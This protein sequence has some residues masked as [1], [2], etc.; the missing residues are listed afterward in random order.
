MRI[1][2]KKET[3]LYVSGPQKKNYEIVNHGPQL[4]HPD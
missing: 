4:T 2:K 3:P 1:K